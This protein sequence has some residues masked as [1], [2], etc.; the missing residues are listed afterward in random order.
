[1]TDPL[2]IIFDNFSIW[3]LDYSN[4]FS[5][6][7]LVNDYVLYLKLAEKSRLELTNRM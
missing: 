7:Y 2:N 6:L 5:C 1:M 3:S 4:G